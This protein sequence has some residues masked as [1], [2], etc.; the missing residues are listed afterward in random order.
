MPD[1]WTQLHI[2]QQLDSLLITDKTCFLCR[3]SENIRNVPDCFDIRI[4]I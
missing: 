4:E 2:T 1:N 3:S